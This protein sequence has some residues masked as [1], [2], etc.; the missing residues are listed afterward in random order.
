MDIHT[1]KNY[2]AWMFDPHFDE[3][4]REELKG[5]MGQ[6]K[7]IE[8]RFY[9]E[10]S[11]GTGGLRGI[12]GAG[13]NRMNKYTVRK[14][15]Q[16]L[17]NYIKNKGI[18]AISKGVVIAYDCRHMS[19]EFSQEAALVLA[20]NGIKAYVFEDLRST[21]ELS[22]AVRHLKAVAGIVVTAS[23]NP[24]AYNGYKVYWED[25]AQVATKIAEEITKEIQLI[26]DY[27][28][29]IPMDKEE[30]L[31]AG[32]LIYIG[33]EVDE[34]YEKAVIAQSLRGDAI[35][36]VSQ[37]FKIVFTPLHGTGN[38]PIRS[39]LKKVGFENVLVVPQQELPDP[40]FTTV[41]YPNPEERAAFQL[42]ID[43]AKK[44]NAHLI[45]GTDPD[46]DRVGA[47]VKNQ[48]GEYVV[49]TG[50]QTGAL[51]VDYI[52][53]TLK[54]KQELP[55][56]AVIIKTIVT[57]EMGATI[58]EGYGVDVFNTLTGFKYIGE[59]IKEYEAS[60]AKTF[61]F[62]FEES[63]GYLAGTHARDKDAVVASMLICEMAAYYHGK[64]QSLYE[65]LLSLYEK[66]GYHLEDL[67]SITL[68]GKEG[69]EKIQGTLQAF[70][71]NPPTEIG[72]YQVKTVEDYLKQD[73]LPKENVLKFLLEKDA[74][75]ALR[76]S[77]TEP[78]L[79]IYCGVVEDALDTCKEKIQQLMSHITNQL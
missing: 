22:F 52:L 70:R 43:L 20:N 27:Y 74:W 65:G 19:R 3:D 13:T 8:D 29:S 1:I 11:F 26:Y 60:G 2:E 37:D 55:S 6:E 47:V 5:I 25:G 10:L 30:A 7:E 72:G 77:G 51:L 78:K 63:Y 42:A 24:P 38:L 9:K 4:T 23:H 75:V 31:R 15:T 35:H 50:N 54:E 39:V 71:D 44:E 41:S 46:C 73:K 67:K 79:K 32:L 59:K 40:N 64:G 18:E 58:A 53:S 48:E 69:M 36:Q 28:T 49:L 34:V 17:A 16:G 21:P 62:G 76:P 33:E 66:Y 45:I 68:E 12:I 56:N 57:S 14:A 61:L